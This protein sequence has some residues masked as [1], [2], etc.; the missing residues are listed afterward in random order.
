MCCTLGLEGCTLW[1]TECK[2]PTPITA[3]GNHMIESVTSVDGLLRFEETTWQHRRYTAYEKYTG[4]APRYF[5]HGEYLY[6]INNFLDRTPT[7][8][9]KFI[10]L[11]GLWFD[12]I[13]AVRQCSK[14]GDDDPDRCT[15]YFDMTFSVI[16]KDLERIIELAATELVDNFSR[17]PEDKTN[18]GQEG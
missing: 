11:R 1:R 4:E 7:I 13:E 9:I 2:L 14:C 5:L 6:V 16:G 18:D 10:T 12:P 15:P 3:R 8:P 17:L